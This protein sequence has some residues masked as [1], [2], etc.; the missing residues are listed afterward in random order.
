MTATPVPAPG[1]QPAS[2][3]LADAVRLAALDATDIRTPTRAV[4]LRPV[5]RLAARALRVPVAQINVLT[6][7]AQVPVVA[8]AL[9]DPAPE[10]WETAVG[11]DTSYCQH[12]V[13][14]RAPLLVEDAR[15]HP[16]VRHSRA[17]TDSGVVAYAGVPVRAPAAVG[18]PAAGQVLGTV[19][20]VD[21][22][23]RRWTPEDLA[24]LEDLADAITAELE[25]R[26]SSAADAAHGVAAAAE[27]ALR[28][29]DAALAE[30]EGRFGTL[31][32]SMP[33]LA[34]MA[35]AAGAVFWYNRRWY[36]YTGTTPERMRGD[37]WSSVHHPDHAARVA[38]GFRAAVAAGEPWEDTFPLRGRDGAF[39]WFLSRA[40]PV[41]AA[42][43][44]ARR[45]FGTNTDVTERIAADAER[46]RLLAAEREARRAAEEAGR[47]RTRFLAT[48]SH[49][50][51]TPLN[52]IGGYAEL[53][54]MGLRGPVTDAQHADLARIRRSQQ[55][56]LGL[57]ND[58][59]N[60]AKLESGTV[61]FARDDVSVAAALQD[62]STMIL[63]QAAAKGLAYRVDACPPALAARADREKLARCCSTC[64]RTR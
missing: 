24:L 52:A 8:C 35:D 14:S 23:P 55:H 62:L 21:F 58:V 33:Q 51:R 40:V 44:G 43:A 25:V 56:L 31:A 32:D 39:R 27:T 5:V 42:A 6:A 17:T 50:L 63:P 59:L 41:D 64:C 29:A 53:L 47:A 61:A 54:D 30:S 19:C 4:A 13:A 49:E 22:A 10:R 16:L 38:A 34:W 36:E 7:D 9:A 3:A 12:V 15:D 45:W 28:R 57:I 26:G 46:D 1:A 60:F 2:A 37:G 48:M 18:P 11:L 20:V